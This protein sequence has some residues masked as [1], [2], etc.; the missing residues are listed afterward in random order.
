MENQGG[1]LLVSVERSVRA[2]KYYEVRGAYSCES[3]A[4]HSVKDREG[5]YYVFALN[6]LK[7]VDGEYY[8]PLNAFNEKPNFTV[9]DD[10]TYKKQFNIPLAE[11]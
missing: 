9:G 2:E 3:S 1:F 8:F 6:E 4:R 7:H 10:P 5:Q 11:W